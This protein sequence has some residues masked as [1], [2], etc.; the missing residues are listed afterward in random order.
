MAN[1]WH[2]ELGLQSKTA[3][4]KVPIALQEG[5]TPKLRLLG[6]LGEGLRGKTFNARLADGSLVAAKRLQAGAPAPEPDQL[7]RLSPTGARALVA[8]QEVF[9]ERGERW[10][11]SERAGGLSL[12]ALLERGRLAPMCAVYVAIAVLDALAALHQAGL[13]HGSIHSGNVHVG[14]DGAVRLSDYCLTPRGDLREAR[15]RAADVQATGLLLCG[16]LRIAPDGESGSRTAASPLGV[17]AR[18]LAKSAPRGKRMGGYAAVDARLALW[19]AAGRLATRRLQAQARERLAAQV[20]LALEPAPAPE[21]VPVT[22]EPASAR[23]GLPALVAAFALTALLVT[24]S[25]TSAALGSRAANASPPP[26]PVRDEHLTGSSTLAGGAALAGAAAPP[27]DPPPAPV[28]TPVPRLITPPQPPAP[29]SAG[30]VSGVT[31]RLVDPGCGAG[32]NC[33]LHVEVWVHPSPSP[34]GVS[35]T[36]RSDDLCTGAEVNLGGG[37]YTAQA[38]WTHVASESTV[39]LPKVKAQALMAVSEAPARAASAPV[40]LGDRTG[41]C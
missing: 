37:S 28:E 20:A 35:W 12:R 26:P 9:V 36:V 15:L 21:P 16:M 38:G 39:Q 29:P 2:H 8:V 13:W 40:L 6:Q 34:R 25:L 3:P 14:A 23:R 32:S 22:P 17:V 30:P 11:V 27:A 1:V 33:P 10:V 5:Q 24:A 31:V 4:H 19:E 7:A 41:P 18:R